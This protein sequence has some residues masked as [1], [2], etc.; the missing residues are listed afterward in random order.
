MKSAS[1]KISKRG[2]VLLP[3][4][5]RKK[6]EIKTGMHMLITQ[7]DNKIVLQ[8]VPSFTDK[9]AGVTAR[10]FGKSAEDVQKHLDE[11]RKDR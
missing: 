8:P 3:S 4:S 10:S 1:V 9:L 5:L 7:S 6:M 2:Y 11:G